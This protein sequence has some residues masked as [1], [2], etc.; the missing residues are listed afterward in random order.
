LA[1]AAQAAGLSAEDES[2]VVGEGSVPALAEEIRASLLDQAFSQRR[3]AFIDSQLRKMPEHELVRFEFYIRSH[4]TRSVV[5]KIMQSEVDKVRSPPSLT[6]SNQSAYDIFKKSESYFLPLTHSLPR[7]T[8][9]NPHTQLQEQRR[10]VEQST[11]VVSSEP[12]VTITDDMAIVVGGLS[13]L[14]VGETVS[15]A[16]EVHHSRASSSSPSSSS[17]AAGG[18]ASEKTRLDLSDIEAAAQM[19]M[20]EGKVANVQQKR[21]EFLFARTGLFQPPEGAARALATLFSEEEL[22][23][24][25]PGALIRAAQ[26]EDEEEDDEGEGEGEG[27][28]EEEGEDEDEEERQR[29]KKPSA[30]RGQEEEEQE[31]DEL[32]S[33]SRAC[34]AS[35]SSLAR[36]A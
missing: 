35:L 14:M 20:S 12:D 28:E 13:K 22:L 36:R 18:G 10:L 8:R 34:A 15:A 33:I 5:K 9:T 19:L 3:S 27:E 4:F 31:E 24:L 30:K 6:P 26:E 1:A 17:A 2:S 16:M 32:E 23:G 25:G 21:Q 7:T 29:W 11:G